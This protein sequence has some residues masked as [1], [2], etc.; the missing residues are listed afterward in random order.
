MSSNSINKL[1]PAAVTLEFAPALA[2]LN[3]DFSLWKVEAPKEF[4]GVGSAL[5]TIR[6]DEAE[7]GSTHITARKLGALFQAILPSTPNLTRAYGQRASKISQTSSVSPQTRGKYGV[8][9]SRVGSDATSIWAA[10][11]SGT[12]AIAVHLLACLLARMWDGPEATSIRAEIVQKRREIVLADMSQSN[13]VEIISLAAAKQDLTRAQLAEWDASARSWLRTADTVKSRQQ[14]QLTL[15]TDNV[16]GSVNQIS[17]TY[18]SVITAWKNS[19][20]QMDGLIEGISQQATSGEILLA[21]SAWHLFPDLV[22]VNPRT[23]Q[24]YQNDHIFTSG[25]VLT[26][27]L[28][29]PDLDRNGVYWS[30]PLA[31]LRYY[32][33]PVVSSCSIDSSERSRLSLTELLQAFLG[34]FLQGWGEAGSDNTVV[35]GW[36]SRLSSILNDAASAG[37]VE[38]EALI[39]GAAEHSWLNL[40][41]SAARHYMESTGNEKLV[42]KKLISLGRRHGKAF[43]GLPKA[44]LFGLLHRG[45]F[46]GL[47]QDE[48]DRID[49]LRKF[50]KD[51]CKEL[52]LESH[53]MFI[54][55]RHKC[56]DSSKTVYEY[57]T[58]V[59]WNRHSTKRK[60]DQSEQ[61][62]EVHRRWLYAGSMDLRRE[63]LLDQRYEQRLYQLYSTNHS[64]SYIV[65]D[66][67]SV[68][69]GFTEWRAA[70]GDLRS[71]YHS[72][73]EYFDAAKSELIRQEF[74]CR[75]KVYSA[76]GEDV[77][78]RESQLIEDFEPDQMGIFWDQ[79][80]RSYPNSRRT[81]WYRCMYG[82]T[83][84]A[85]IFV[86]EGEEKLADLVHTVKQD[87]QE[88]YSLFELNKINS[89]SVVDQ[90]ARIFQTANVEGDPHMQSAKAV[91]TAA[92]LYRNFPDATIDVRVIQ[93][94]LWRA[95]WV[96]SAV[97]QRFTSLQ[98]ITTTRATPSCLEPYLLDRASAFACINMFESG[99]YDANPAELEN[100]MAMASGDSIYV[101][102]A[103]LCGPSQESYSRAIKRVAGNI[104]RPG[105]AFLVPP[106]DPLI[107][108]VS[109]SEWPQISCN[110]FDWTLRDCFENTSLHLSFTGASTPVNLNFSGGQDAEV[111]MLETLVSV[112]DNGKWIGDLN[113]LKTF[114]SPQLNLISLCSDRHQ[115]GAAVVPSISKYQMTSIETWL[116]L[117]DTPE[118]HFCVV[119]AYGN[120]EARLAT[121]SISV[122]KGYF[123]LVVPDDICWNCLENT[124]SKVSSNRPV[125]VII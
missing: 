70:S 76:K 84:I 32:G 94:K 69:D 65:E 113:I 38:A 108:T 31:R 27:G 78:E 83:N 68:P 107:K 87:S 17:D 49:F 98:T 14:K 33:A 7:N 120:W 48:D 42:A 75:A 64:G 55:Y 66:W 24:V 105:I 80:G 41:F 77:I 111:Y 121:G 45:S 124:I 19:L 119:R 57:A 59:P 110:E 25:G 5:S 115:H 50:A 101:I 79:M 15:I 28:E 60:L 88:M 10:A 53:Q 26:I 109:I 125:I 8:F 30:L 13:T 12:A 112:H 16:Q 89:T 71:V 82:E 104:G 21:L 9:S 91:S 74:E 93:R 37:S 6:R 1:A 116:E 72:D 52:R 54:R 18:E 11:T 92:T 122:A 58:A 90:L 29:K 85:A 51:A 67:T 106:V 61:E 86:I 34:C 118:E 47:I 44:P 117:V 22:V 102:A 36:L 62:S 63:K 95:Q 43:L 123:T 56:L 40:L 114:V 103:L 46:V 99:R 39:S 100:V 20:T 3:F 35:I 81:P 23:T 96:R 2:N 97:A 4:D 73:R